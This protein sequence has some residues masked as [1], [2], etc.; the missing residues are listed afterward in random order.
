MTIK[1]R[2]NIVDNPDVSAANTEEYKADCL[3][4]RF[5]TAYDR[6]RGPGPGNV[7]VEFL[8]L[9]L[10]SSH[11]SSTVSI[12]SPDVTTP[13]PLEAPVLAEEGQAAQRPKVVQRRGSPH[14]WT[15]TKHCTP[16]DSVVALRGRDHDLARL[17]PPYDGPE[18]E[19]CHRERPEGEAVQRGRNRF[20][21]HHIA[22]VRHVANV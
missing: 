19:I 22:Q 11:R 17:A 6:E 18:V 9:L 2:W 21:E 12:D 5:R 16:T 15:V 3:E 14:V 1:G 7:K 8:L 13:V 4:E 20:E 10:Q